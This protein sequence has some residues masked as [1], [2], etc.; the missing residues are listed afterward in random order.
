MI[1]ELGNAL[2]DILSAFGVEVAH[3]KMTHN[4]VHR[5]E[6]VLC[7]VTGLVENTGERKGIMSLEFSEPAASFLLGIMIGDPEGLTS[8]M[9]LSALSELAIATPPTGV[10]GKRIQGILNTMSVQKVSLPLG[11]GTLT[12]GLSIS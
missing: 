12:A 2:Q 7:I 9:G 6:G 1:T 3:L 11:G 8:E 10:V 5:V 4:D